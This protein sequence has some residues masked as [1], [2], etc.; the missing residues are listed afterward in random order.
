VVIV[1][2]IFR[3][4]FLASMVPVIVNAILN[5]HQLVI[6][7]VS[8]VQKGDFHRSRLGEK[9]RGKILAG[10]VTRKMRSIAQY[11]IR[12]PNGSDAQMISEEPGAGRASMSGSM[13]GMGRTG[14]ASLKASS[15]RAPSLLGMTATM[16]SLS[17]SQQQQQFSPSP[18]MVPQPGQQPGY[19]PQSI[20]ENAPP[21]QYQGVE[22][23]DPSD[24]TPTDNR[25]SFLPNLQLQDGGAMD[26]SPVD[27]AGPFNDTRHQHQPGNYQNAYHP[28]QQQY[29]SS[30]SGLSGHA[31]EV[32]RPGPSDEG[33]NVGTWNTRD[34]YSDSTPYSAY[35]NTSPDPNMQQ[36]HQQQ[37]NQ[38]QTWTMESQHGQGYNGGYGAGGEEVTR[39]ASHGSYDSRTGGND[40]GGG[41]GLRVANRDSTES[42]SADEGWKRDVLAQMN[43]AGGPG[44]G[45]HAQ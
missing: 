23:H 24:R 11:S 22:L 16:N 20:P 25:H 34:F 36:Q 37:Q 35:E 41:G 5:E 14:P 39:Y 26:Y 38:Q 15:T 6:D 1:V 44:G 21:S 29:E 9:Q 45:S 3:R 2:E 17:L 27:R 19:Y 10:W 12:D 33:Y 28:Q 13:M 42:E 8:F 31:P 43:F 32:V 4:N 18:G 7:I 40:G 30:G